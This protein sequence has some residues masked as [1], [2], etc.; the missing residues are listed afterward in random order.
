MS[1]TEYNSFNKPLP[2][3]TSHDRMSQHSFQCLV[4]QAVLEHTYI[5]FNLKRVSETVS[6]KR[7]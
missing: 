7:I 2:T 4:A 5:R 6:V 1:R 3:E